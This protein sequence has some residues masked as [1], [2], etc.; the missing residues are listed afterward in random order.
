[1]FQLFKEPETK[2][3]A[4]EANIEVEDQERQYC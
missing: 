4:T 1:M 3:S 2:A